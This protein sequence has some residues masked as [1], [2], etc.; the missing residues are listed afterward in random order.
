MVDDK[1]RP[2]DAVSSYKK[3]L[4]PPVFLFMA[5]LGEKKSGRERPL[6]F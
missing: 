6:V 1:G 4:L 5:V 3:F 2:A